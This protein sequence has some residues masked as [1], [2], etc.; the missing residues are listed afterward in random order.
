MTFRLDEATRD[1]IRETVRH[2]PHRSSSAFI[3]AAISELLAREAVP[4]PLTSAGKSLNSRQTSPYRPS[5]RSA[6]LSMLA[7]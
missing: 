1:R 7:A 3:R 5:T 2:S 6:S 4:L